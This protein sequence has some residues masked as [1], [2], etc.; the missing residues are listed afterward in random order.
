MTEK[1]MKGAIDL[2]SQINDNTFAKYQEKIP[3]SNSVGLTKAQRTRQAV[4]KDKVDS[5]KEKYKKVYTDLLKTV[6]EQSNEV[7]A[8]NIKSLA[9]HIRK[10]DMWDKELQN[11]KMSVREKE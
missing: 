4:M 5:N 1:A 10:V 3:N 9:R 11:R 7:S 6:N 2:Y 8:M